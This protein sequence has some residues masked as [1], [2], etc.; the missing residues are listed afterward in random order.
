MV[1]TVDPR[2][3][4]S[5]ADLKEQRDDAA[6]AVIGDRLFCRWM[7][8]HAQRLEAARGGRTTLQVSG[9]VG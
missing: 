3:I 1:T 5:T 7:R 9:V 2:P 8:R 4:D 6:V